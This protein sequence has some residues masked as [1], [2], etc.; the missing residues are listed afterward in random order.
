M[1]RLLVVAL[2]AVVAVPVV[3][4]LRRYR[5]D[6]DAARARIAA[7]ERRVISTPWGRSNTPSAARASRSSWCT[8]KPASARPSASPTRDS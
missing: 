7:V 1:E 5:R 3:G 6:L 4:L 8:T 2:R